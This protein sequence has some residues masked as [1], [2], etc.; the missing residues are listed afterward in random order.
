MQTYSFNRRKYSIVEAKKRHHTHQTDEL[1]NIYISHKQWISA[2]VTADMQL[3]NK[4]NTHNHIIVKYNNA[5][6]FIL[7]QISS[8]KLAEKYCQHSR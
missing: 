7:Q 2:L 1:I 4:E 3:Y 5:I 6:G 8:N